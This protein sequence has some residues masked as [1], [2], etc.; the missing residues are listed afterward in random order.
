V[1]S[2]NDRRVRPDLVLSCNRVIENDGDVRME[3]V[4]ILIGYFHRRDVNNITGLIG[5]GDRLR[6]YDSRDSVVPVY[7]HS[8]DI[9]EQ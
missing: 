9:L 2:T 8:S 7:V 1:L 6:E 3:V 4:Y 5:E